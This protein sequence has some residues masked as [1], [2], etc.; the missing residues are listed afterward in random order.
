MDLL[1]AMGLAQ[2]DQNMGERLR[3]VVGRILTVLMDHLLVVAVQTQPE[4][5]VRRKGRACFAEM[6]IPLVR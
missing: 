4:S 3:L 1:L 2:K 6:Q 5:V